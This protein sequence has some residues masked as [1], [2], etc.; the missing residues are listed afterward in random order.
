ML[1]WIIALVITAGLGI[2]GLNTWSRLKKEH[3]EARNLPLDGVDFSRLNDGKYHGR[4]EGGMYKWRANECDVTVLGG[5]VIDIKL[6]NSQD[7]GAKNTIY[8]PLYERV[9]QDQSLQVDTISGSTLTSN[10]YLKAVEI[11]LIPAQNK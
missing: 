10:A 5:K 6:A 7:P 1:G 3:Q 2:L 4:Y 8:Q 11:A 9:I